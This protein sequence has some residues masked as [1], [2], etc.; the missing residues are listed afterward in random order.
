MRGAEDAPE[1]EALEEPGLLGRMD[2][3]E[4]V[5]P[6]TEDFV[7]GEISGSFAALAVA[8]TQQ[9]AIRVS[10]VRMCIQKEKNYIL[11]YGCIWAKLER[12]RPF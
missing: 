1:A 9:Q 10:R 12:R 4:P 2:A 8:R 5:L 3:I 11:V 6:P 7:D